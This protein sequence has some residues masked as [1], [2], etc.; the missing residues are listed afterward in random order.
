M[1][2]SCK[3]AT[4]ARVFKKHGP[5][6]YSNASV[7]DDMGTIMEGFLGAD[8][9]QAQNILKVVEEG[10]VDGQGYPHPLATINMQNFHAIE[11]MLQNQ[12]GD[13]VHHD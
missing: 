8:V 10:S 6:L 12:L 5:A 13:A 2:L 3:A 1:L 9:I 4:A 7:R 11:D